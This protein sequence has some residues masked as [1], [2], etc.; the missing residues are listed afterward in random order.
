[1]SGLELDEPSTA[2]LD[3]NFGQFDE[4]GEENKSDVSREYSYL[5]TP[6]SIV[7]Q[8]NQRRKEHLALKNLLPRLR[9]PDEFKAVVSRMKENLDYRPDINKDNCDESSPVDSKKTETLPPVVFKRPKTPPPAELPK[10]VFSNYLESHER[11]S[12]DGFHYFIYREKCARPTRMLL[13]NSDQ[14]RSPM[15]SEQTVKLVA[16]KRKSLSHKSD[17]DAAFKKLSE[18]NVAKG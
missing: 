6:E 5:K 7:R 2:E 8:F 3:L 16:T 12:K 17:S 18:S 14:A 13:M 1:M 9:T 4:G 11:V 10:P 15:D